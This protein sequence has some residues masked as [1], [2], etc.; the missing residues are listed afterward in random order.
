MQ[1]SERRV[2]FRARTTPRRGRRALARSARCS[3][4]STARCSIFASTPDRVRVDPPRLTALLPELARPA[5]R[6]R[7]ADHRPQRSPTPTRLF[8]DLAL[9]VAGQHGLERRAADGSIHLHEAS[10]RGSSWLRARARRASPRVTRACCSRTRAR[11]SRSTTGARR[12]SPRTCTG[13]CATMLRNTAGQ[14][15]MA[16]AAG[17]EN[18]RNQARRT[19]AK[20]TAILEYMAE[21]P[22]CRPRAGVRRRRLDRRVRL[23]SPSTHLARLGG[24]GRARRDARTLPAARRRAPVRAW[25]AQR[26]CDVR[27]FDSGASLM[28]DLDL[29]LIGNGTIG[30]LVD[31]AGSIV[32][33]CFPRFDSDPTF[34]ALL[35]DTRVRRASAASGRSTSST[36]CA[37][38]QSLRSTNTA[39]L[40]T[41]PLRQG[42]QAR[43]R[44]HRS[45]ALRLSI[46]PHLPSGRAGPAAS[47]K[48]SGSRAIVVRLRPAVDYGSE[49]PASTV[50][51][52]THPLRDA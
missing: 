20:C 3:S 39:V 27:T 18:P 31:A 26:A 15:R 13:R 46:R 37:R 14:R 35:D 49:R 22:F 34:C 47:G 6:C 24:E 43:V 41:R 12:A 40:T 44:D 2:G 16:A 28:R 21:P 52:R 11:R 8:P 42:R 25:L 1:T 51:S 30:L 5:R 32:W 33:G 10:M 48:L 7:R 17:Q 23:S 9:P 36:A 38:E 50:G 19:R 45:C 29:A 4:T